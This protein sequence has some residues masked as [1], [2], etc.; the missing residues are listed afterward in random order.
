L[1][2]L[3]VEAEFFGLKIYFLVA[4]AFSMDS[5]LL[6]FHIYEN[7]FCCVGDIVVLS[8]LLSCCKLRLTLVY[9]VSVV[10]LSDRRSVAYLASFMDV[11]SRIG[12]IKL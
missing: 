7:S 3:R 8:L 9:H 6:W 11:A 1:H 5:V 12:S 10:I 2:L 4:D